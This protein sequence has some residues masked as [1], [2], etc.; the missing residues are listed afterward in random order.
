MKKIRL[1]YILSAF[2]LVTALTFALAGCGS[3]EAS[4]AVGS[5][6]VIVQTADTF[7]PDGFLNDEGEADG[8]EIDVLKAVAEKLPQY[9]FEYTAAPIDQITVNLTSK[10]IDIAALEFGKSPEREASFTFTD[11]PYSTLVTRFIVLADNAEYDENTTIDD[12]QGKTVYVVKGGDADTIQAYN[13]E[14]P[15]NPIDIQFISDPATCVNDLVSGK[16]DA[17]IRGEVAIPAYGAA[18]GVKLKGV[19]EPVRNEKCYFMLQK[20]ADPALKEGIDSAVKKL[21]EDGTIPALHKK[22]HHDVDYTPPYTYQ[23]VYNG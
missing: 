21:I 10:R 22:W 16:A 3:K 5:K 6:K 9:E 19:A 20:D 8:F 17:F 1:L 2:T 15:D 23:P 13:D 11:E 7:D 4:A 14:H 12:F 18:Y